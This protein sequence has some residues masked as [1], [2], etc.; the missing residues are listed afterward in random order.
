[1][2]S[3]FA[4]LTVIFAIWFFF[5]DVVDAWLLLTI[6]ERL[7]ARDAKKKAKAL[8]DSMAK[9]K[10]HGRWRVLGRYVI[11]SESAPKTLRAPK[12]KRNYRIGRDAFGRYTRVYETDAPHDPE[13]LARI[14]AELD[15][16]LS[17][18]RVDDEVK[19]L[20]QPTKSASSPFIR[21]VEKFPTDVVQGDLIVRRGVY[22]MF[23]GG[24]FQRMDKE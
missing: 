14:E 22:Y 24:R 5:G 17:G 20:Y 16:E 4:V 21:V 23:D 7:K 19:K 15:A 13:H 12:E 18:R 2:P 3:L 10:D 1:V 8:A 6:K 11:K 9:P